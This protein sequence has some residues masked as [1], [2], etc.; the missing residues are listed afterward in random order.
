MQFFLMYSLFQVNYI[1]LQIAVFVY[2]FVVETHKGV[3]VIFNIR[4]EM[5]Y[6]CIER[7]FVNFTTSITII[8]AHIPD[9]WPICHFSLWSH[10]FFVT[11]TFTILCRSLSNSLYSSHYLNR[12]VVDVLVYERMYTFVCLSTSTVRDVICRT[13]GS[14]ERKASWPAANRMRFTSM[15]T[16][17]LCYLYI[18]SNCHLET[19]Y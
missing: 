18:Q 10:L 17:L 7:R 13:I 19:S 5:L 11:I 9:R 6:M 8:G 15:C 3:K 2:L 16:A 4:K 12:S 1:H 14:S